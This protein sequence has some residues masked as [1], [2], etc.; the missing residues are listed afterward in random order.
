MSASDKQEKE[1]IKK[2]AGQILQLAHD[3][4]LIHLRFFDTALARLKRQAKWGTECVATDGAYFWY[5]PVFVLKAYQGEP[6][7]ITRCYLHT[8]LHCIF[9][10]GFQYQKLDMDN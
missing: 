8:L 3:D 5:D 10:H 4:I 2:I 1:K 6:K 9:S 7:Y